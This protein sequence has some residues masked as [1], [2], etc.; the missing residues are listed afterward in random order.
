MAI[1][2]LRDEH[3]LGCFTMEISDLKTKE[4]FLLSIPKS[5]LSALTPGSQ[6]QG[7][8]RSPETVTKRNNH[9][10]YN[11]LSLAPNR[12]APPS[13]SYRG[14]SLTAVHCRKFGS[15]SSTLDIAI[16]AVRGDS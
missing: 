10:Q 4:D 1:D 14:R 16:S 15:R 6:A 9:S 7:L 11:P 5:L 13:V 3:I 12:A 2:D 8:H